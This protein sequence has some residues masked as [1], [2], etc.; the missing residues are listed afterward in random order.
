MRARIARLRRTARAALLPAL[1][2]LGYGLLLLHHT[3]FVAGGSDSSGYLNSTSLMLAGQIS[4]PVRTLDLLGLDDSYRNL[5]IPLGFIPGRQ[6]KTMVPS[7]PPGLPLLMATATAIAGHTS[8]AF[9]VPPLCAVGCVLLIGLVARELGLSLGYSMAS[10]AILACYPVFVFQAVQ[11]MSDVPAAFL[12]TASVFAAIRSSRH[13]AYS[14]VAGVAFGLSVLVRPTDALLAVPLVFVLT[15]GAKRILLF[16]LGLLPLVTIFALYNLI[17]YGSPLLTGYGPLLGGGGTQLGN[18][19]ARAQHY[20]HWLLT[21][22]TPLVPLGYCAASLDRSIPSRTRAMLITWF[23]AFF[24]FYS[25]Y[26]PYETWWYA[27]FLLPGVG[28]MIIAAVLLASN[29]LAAMAGSSPA[30]SAQRRALVGGLLLLA[31]VLWT[32]IAF[33]DQN[34]V[35]KGYKGDRI[36][37]EACRLAARSLPANAIVA[38]MQFSGAL[39]YYTDL[40]FVRWDYIDPGNWAGLRDRAAARGVRWYAMLAP[41]E[42]EDAK[43]RMPARWR[44]MARIRDIVI[45]K[46]ETE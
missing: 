19:P 4:A 27:R 12:A 40:A 3:S 11:A 32:E 9:L 5:F 10:A 30:R 6:P 24:L 22:F 42:V 34:R 23:G 35:H 31:T 46:L 37:P 44:E 2:L 26:S 14:A 18:F 16:G 7:Y 36:Y 20:S 38:S 41:F 33:I 13:P 39:L 29:G 1:L 21:L 8:A 15:P 17:T 28:G 43:K 45:W 25:C